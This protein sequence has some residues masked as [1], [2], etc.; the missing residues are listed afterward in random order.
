VSE[1]EQLAQR[2]LKHIQK[3][4]EDQSESWQEDHVLR[5]VF[6][7]LLESCLGCRRVAA[8]FVQV[9]LTSSAI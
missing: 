9:H 5:A 2:F 6:T 1:C 4:I 3:V 8:S 7:G